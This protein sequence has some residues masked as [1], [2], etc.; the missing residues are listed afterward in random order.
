MKQIDLFGRDSSEDQQQ[1]Y[2]TKIEAP[3]Y[4]P[5]NKKPHLLE[6]RDHSKTLRLVKEIDA[7][8]LPEEEK[9]FLRAAA[10]RHTV[11]NYEKIADYYAHASPEMQELMEN[12]GLVIID[13]KKAVE[14]GYVRVCEEIRDQFLTEYG[15]G[16]EG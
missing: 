16:D 7:S 3:V 12:S 8:G 14:R 10:T 4:E 1:K 5:K 11:F 2:S 13:F 15:Q 6:L 9:E